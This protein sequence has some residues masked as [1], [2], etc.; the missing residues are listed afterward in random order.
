MD[1][2]GGEAKR[3]AKEIQ[4][5]LTKEH[6]SRFQH[7]VIQREAAFGR[8]GSTRAA[9]DLLR[10]MTA[11]CASALRLR[12]GVDPF[13]LAAHYPQLSCLAR[14]PSSELL[15]RARRIRRAR[16]PLLGNQNARLLFEEL[17]LD[18]EKGQEGLHG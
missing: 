17:F 1:F 13:G 3:R 9:E 5:A 14:R 2:C 11:A 15:A 8:S 18:L 7:P 10:A 6:G 16:Q 4:S 12:S